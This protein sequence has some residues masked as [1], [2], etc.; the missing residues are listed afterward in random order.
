MKKSLLYIVIGCFLSLF[1]SAQPC[2][3][4]ISFHNQ[5][6]VDNF[7]NDYPG[8]T[9]IEGSVS[10]GS[11]I[12]N[13]NGLTVL[14]SIGGNL[15]FSYAVD[16]E[17]FSGL[18]NLTYIGGH[19]QITNT[20]IADLS[21]LESLSY[22]GADLWIYSNPYLTSLIGLEELDSV[23]Q[24][25]VIGDNNELVSLQGLGSLVSAG[26]GL[27][28]S[29]NAS[30]TSLN[31]LN[32]FTG[33]GDRLEI[34]NNDALTDLSSLEGIT[35]VEGTI[36]ILDNDFLINLNG[37]HNIQSVGWDLTIQKNLSLTS[38]DGL[39]NLNSVA[40]SLR[41]IEN[42]NLTSLMGLEQ[43]NF[44]GETLEIQN[45][46][47]LSDIS[48]LANINPDALINLSIFYN[49]S[50]GNC[51]IQSFCAYL[52][53]PNGK[54]IIHHNGEG[55]NHV[56]DIAS[57][58]DILLPCLPYGDYYFISQAHIDNFP[59]DFPECTQLEGN[60]VINGANITD[61]GGLYQVTSIGSNL[62]LSDNN[63]L[64]GL[65][66]LSN[67]FYLGNALVLIN[68]DLLPGLD[69][70]N[71]LALGEDNYLL[72]LENDNLSLCN[73]DNFCYFINNYG[74]RTNFGN[75]AAGC[76]NINEAASA[77][78][79]LSITGPE[80]DDFFEIYP[81]PALS[82]SKIMVL[83]QS[84]ST[85]SIRL[86]NATGQLLAHLPAK[87]EPAQQYLIPDVDSLP[88]GLYFLR[89]STNNQAF[90][91]KMLVLK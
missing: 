56:V 49:P 67:L 15:S 54:V 57:A 84:P 44:I 86:F 63:S 70:L 90:T 21:G 16:L 89:V 64:P 83:L 72:I 61:L 73:Q 1:S 81:N 22:I 48:L 47:E 6:E 13:L 41:I 43:I 62:E 60:V 35:V 45:N 46:D 85:A 50:L 52:A 18:N 30:L 14:T 58:C 66:Q 12:T 53:N 91:R 59:F 80:E 77:C 24:R 39:N 42:D 79:I 3:M 40:K 20:N 88:A 37:L 19:L 75:N 25:V 74:G 29:D 34:E 8:C 26:L 9:S 38:L 68:N 31:G 87:E 2:P 17:S 10:I 7:Q 78:G 55:C 71:N 76:S 82:G 23:G 4:H 11:E 51:E 27:Y 33:I 28:I 36:T 5:S 32:A 69:G 65:L